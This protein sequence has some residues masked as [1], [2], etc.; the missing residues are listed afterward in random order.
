LRGGEGQEY[1]KNRYCEM[2]L[3]DAITLLGYFGFDRGYMDILVEAK[4]ESGG[5]S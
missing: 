2:L 5:I 1:D 3:D 4:I